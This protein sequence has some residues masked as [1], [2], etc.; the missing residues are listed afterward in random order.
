MRVSKR[1]NAS[2][3]ILHWTAVQS[4]FAAPQATISSIKSGSLPSHSSDN[5]SPAL[6][7][8]WAFEASKQNSMQ[9]TGLCM[10]TGTQEMVLSN[11]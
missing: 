11:Q 2:I 7:A 4:E 5:T 6:E 10:L 3:N 8:T 1:K 9:T